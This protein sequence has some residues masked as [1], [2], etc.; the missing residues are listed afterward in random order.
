MN[1]NLTPEAAAQ[2]QEGIS[3]LLSRWAAF[4]MAVQ[5]EWGGRD[6]GQKPQQLADNIFHLLTQSKDRVYI[7]DVELMLDEFMDTLNTVIED[8]S[9]E[10]V[11]EKLM[12]MHEECSEGNFDSIK[13]LRETSIPNVSYVR[14]G[15]NDSEDSED[16]N[17][18]DTLSKDNSSEM[19]IDA[20]KSQSSPSQ[21]DSLPDQTSQRETPPQVVDGWTVVPSRRSKGKKK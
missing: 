13:K 7:D 20:P 11:A 18:D 17:E 14:Q 16:N 5:N 9:I 3:L 1:N 6:S 10:E 15:S 19:E 12:V 4:Q 21:K 2:L 8:G